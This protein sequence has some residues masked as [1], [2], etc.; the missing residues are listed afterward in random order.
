MEATLV[1]RWKCDPTHANTAR[2][3][4]TTVLLLASRQLELSPSLLSSLGLPEHV[5]RGN[6]PSR[7]ANFMLEHHFTSGFLHLEDVLGA[8][9]RQESAWMGAKHRTTR[10]AEVSK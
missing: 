4:A 8:P 1:V 6:A 9:S 10:E 5:C 7:G 2:S 3:V